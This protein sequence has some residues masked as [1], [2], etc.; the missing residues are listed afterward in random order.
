MDYPFIEVQARNTD[1]SRATVTFQLAGG[2][3]PVSEADIVTALAERLAA[4]PGVT[5]VTATRHHVVQTD[6]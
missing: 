4:V 2:D 1:G 3:L 6:L 5:G